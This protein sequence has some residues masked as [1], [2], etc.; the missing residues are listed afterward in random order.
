MASVAAVRHLPNF[1][2]HPHPL[3]PHPPHPHPGEHS[4][5]G[6]DDGSPQSPGTT[7]P[8]PSPPPGGKGSSLLETPTRKNKRKLSE[9]RKR[10]S[11]FSI[12]R[13]CPGSPGGSA[14]SESGCSDDGGEADNN[15]L[16]QNHRSRRP[17]RRRLSNDNDDSTLS[18]REDTPGPSGSG[19]NGGSGGLPHGAGGAPPHHNPFFPAGLPP[20]LPGFYLA[21]GRAGFPPPPFPGL[22]LGLPHHP[23]LPTGLATDSRSHDPHRDV[24]SSRSNQQHLNLPGLSAQ[25]LSRAESPDNS[26]DDNSMLEGSSGGRK[27]RKNYKNMTR[28]RRVEAN[29]RE[30]TR[31]HTISAAFDALRRAVPSYSYNQ[32]LS[33]LAILR[34]ACT[35]IM[36]LGRLADVDCSNAEAPIPVTFGDCVDLCTRTIQTEGRARRRH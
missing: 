36:A 4:S 2:P 31:V 24:N 21:D 3:P 29:A 11:D 12:K 1:H 20:F 19:K 7:T 23:G 10:G 27:P 26:G 22:P 9:P 28:E 32:K 18:E 34:I 14:M 6:S 16:R 5:G 33:K 17:V 25:D 15:N 8:P 30:R 35:Y 13:L